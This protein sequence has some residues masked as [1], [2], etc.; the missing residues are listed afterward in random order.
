M[1][2]PI[3]SILACCLGAAPLYASA[4]EPAR[5]ATPVCMSRTTPLVLSDAAAAVTSALAALDRDLAATAGTLARQDLAGPAARH[6][7]EQFLVAHPETGPISTLGPDGATLLVQPDDRQPGSGAGRREPPDFATVQRTGQPVMS[8]F[9]GEGP[10]QAAVVLAYPV[11]AADGQLPGAVSLLFSTPAL[12]GPPLQRLLKGLPV[13]VWVMQPDGRILYD[14]DRPE[15]GRLLLTD[16]AYQSFPALLDL[17]RR[18]G[19]EPEGCGSYEYPAAGTGTPVHKDAWWVTVGLHGTDWRVLSVHPSAPADTA[20]AGAPF[21]Q[22][23]L[24]TLAR[25]PALIADLR[26]GRRD[27]AMTRFADLAANHTGIYSLTWID[28]QAV[29]RFG[30]PRGDSLVDVDLKTQTDPASIAIV[31]A[32]ADRAALVVEEPLVEGGNAR[33]TLAPVMDGADYLGSLLWIE[34]L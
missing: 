17:G 28:A 4:A 25:D 21:S 34:R 15:V 22:S 24:R 19:A 2:R 6:A 8:G 29:N 30:Y 10:G 3:L 12:L 7:L 32:I 31:K 23:A 18:I 11:P 14:A 9:V 16:P 5:L 1:R 27:A 33:Y 26:E 20:P 13:E